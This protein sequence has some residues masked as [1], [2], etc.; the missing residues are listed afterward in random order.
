MLLQVGISRSGHPESKSPSYNSNNTLMSGEY[1]T[2]LSLDYA[3]GNTFI[4]LYPRL[5][6]KL[7]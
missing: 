4:T 7:N 3:A 6:P 2:H 5:G 1:K